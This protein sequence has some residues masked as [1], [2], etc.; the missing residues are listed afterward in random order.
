MYPKMNWLNFEKNFTDFDSNHECLA[1]VEATLLKHCI[2]H[3][4]ESESL[5]SYDSS[6]SGE[7]LSCIVYSLCNSVEWELL[8]WMTCVHLVVLVA[9][10]GRLH[11]GAVAPRCSKVSQLRLINAYLKSHLVTDA[12]AWKQYVR[13][14]P[15]TQ[16]VCVRD[17]E[18]F[19]K[20]KLIFSLDTSIL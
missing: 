6:D 1:D 14:R 20:I 9:L 3:G 11:L 18:A 15:E 2:D 4:S 19:F 7:Y 13:V 12:Y 8:L 17:R 10:S 16:N 5:H